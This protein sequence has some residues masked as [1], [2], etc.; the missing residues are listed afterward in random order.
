MKA[1]L[2]KLYGEEYFI[3]MWEGFCDTYASIRKCNDGNI[4]QEELTKIKCPVLIIHGDK[5]PMV[6]PIHPEYLEKEIKNS[7]LVFKL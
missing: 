1:P 4:C 7:T 6:D 5:D 3:S 2:L